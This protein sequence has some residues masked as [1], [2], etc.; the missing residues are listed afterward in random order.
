MPAPVRLGLEVLLDVQLPLLRGRRVGLVTNHT[1]VDRL[2]R[3]TVDL[4]HQHPEVNLVAL[5]GPEHGIRGAAAAGEKVGSERDPITGL[6]VHS[7]YGATQRPTRE[8]LAGLDVLVY[9]IQDIG[10]RY[11]TYPYTLAYCMEAAKEVGL[12]VVVLDRPNPIGGELVEGNILDPAFASFV[13]LY[14]LPVRHG[15]TIGE[16]A[17]WF[18]QTVGCDLTVVPMQGWNRSLWWDETGIPFVPMSPNSTGVDMATLYGGTCLFEGTNLSEGRGTTKPFEQVGAPWVDGRRLAAVLNDLNLPGVRFRSVYF[19]P[20]FS[21]HRDQPCQGVQVHILDRKAVRAPE[22]GLH[23]V[24]A[25][26]DLHPAEFAFLEPYREGGRRFFDLLAGTD[27]WRLALEAGATVPDIAA[28][29]AA[30]QAPFL[31]ARANALLY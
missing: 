27:A 20:T 16:L 25:I 31:A 1:G 12:P 21:K 13:G 10:V 6:P 23:M 2:F 5:Y 15:M 9:D 11:Y 7:L 3:S 28:G 14:P 18:N 17:R 19:T 22:L 29:W 24:K 4:L 26:R 30:Q 8:M